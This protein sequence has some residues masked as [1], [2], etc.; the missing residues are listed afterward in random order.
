[1]SISDTLCS[2]RTRKS[3][4]GRQKQKQKG[5]RTDGQTEQES[6]STYVLVGWATNKM[7]KFKFSQRSLLALTLYFSCVT[8]F[9]LNFVTNCVKRVYLTVPLE[10]LWSRQCPLSEDPMLC[11]GGDDY[12]FRVKGRDLPL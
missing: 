8:L 11:C 7:G 6:A 5:G 1:M 3:R 12:R 10:I 4:P 2:G 9:H